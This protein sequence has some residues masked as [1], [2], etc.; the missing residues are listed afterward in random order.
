MIKKFIIAILF[1]TSFMSI[2]SQSINDSINP[3]GYNV[4]YYPNGFK[5]SEGNL[6]NG[7]PDG[8]WITYYVNGIKKSEGNRKNFLLDSIWIFYAEN[9]DTLKKI[10]YVQNK[11]N[12]YYYEYYTRYDSGVN[13]LKSKELYLNDKIQN[14]AFYYY[15]SGELKY[16]VKYKDN[17]KHGKA[18]Q[19]DKN[20]KLIS[21]DEYRYNNLVS[22]QAVNRYNKKGQKDGQWV[23]VYDNG[24]VKNEITYSND[25]PNGVFKEYTPN[26][27][28]LKIDRYENGILKAE[29]T[30]NDSINLTELRVVKEFYKNGNLKAAFIYK[31]SLKYGKQIYYDING[32]IEKAEIYSVLGL[33]IAEGKMDTLGNRQGEWKLYN[34]SGNTMALGK[35]KDNKK[36]GYWKYYYLSGQLFEEG[37]YI[38]NLPNGEWIWYYQTGE[39]MLIENF[40]N[41]IKEGLSYELSIKGDTIAKGEYVEGTKN[42]KWFYKIGDEYSIGKYYY[43]LKSGEWL[44]YYYPEMIKKNICN[45]QEGELAGKYISW[46]MNKRIQSTGNYS[47]GQKSGKWY[48]YLPDGALDYNAEYINGEI[49]KVNDT[50]IK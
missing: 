15:P 48:Y 33:K 25:L 23:E 3:N 20:G 39:I 1:I 40:N 44:H 49:V 41:G 21:I 28:I 32:N 17:Y 7:K 43:N 16:K 47:N 35:Y 27:K 26:G 37:N 12:G 50:V 29:I 31:D 19:Y 6:V 36:D 5:L 24:N 30:K 45:Y 22:H 8:Y 38:N 14:W 2:Y 11:K 34:E 10:N 13:S 4:F 18:F 46:Y 42:G 9:G